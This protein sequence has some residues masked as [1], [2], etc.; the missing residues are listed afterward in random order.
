MEAILFHLRIRL[1]R[2]LDTIH[3]PQIMAISVLVRFPTHRRTITCSTP[4]NRWSSFRIPNPTM[5]S[6]K[7][8]AFVTALTE[9]TQ[10]R[11]IVFVV[12]SLVGTWWGNE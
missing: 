6:N 3:I 2:T 5:V 9:P 11:N 7:E 10:A 4:W 8:G 1:T 12:L